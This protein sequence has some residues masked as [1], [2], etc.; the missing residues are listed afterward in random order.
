MSLNS[1]LPPNA[2]PNH[3]IDHDAVCLKQVWIMRTL[4]DDE[5]VG[6]QLPAAV[7]LHLAQ[8]PACKSLAGQLLAVTSELTSLA[9]SSPTAILQ[10]R[11]NDQ[12][13]TALDH[14]AQMTGRVEVA[15]VMG[16][17]DS[18]PSFRFPLRYGYWVAAAVLLLAFGVSWVMTPSGSSHVTTVSHP[19]AGDPIP[20]DDETKPSNQP[21]FTRIVQE[22]LSADEIPMTDSEPSIIQ[23]LAVTT[24]N[25]P[26]TRS[27]SRSPRQRLCRHRSH[28]EAAMCDK[29]DV[30]HAVIMSPRRNNRRK[31]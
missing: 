24:P 12:L 3:N 7:H 29:A 5:L 13:Q 18:K 25:R 14:G 19:K 23:G 1:H 6:G 9:D 30:V 11:A 4:C 31:P 27:T 26:P 17:F 16:P 15:D 8:C 22:E 10:D 21:T 2:D 28:L 20:L